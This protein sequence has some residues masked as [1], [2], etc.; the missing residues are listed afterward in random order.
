MLAAP[1]PRPRG[2][3]QFEFSLCFRCII[4]QMPML[5]NQRPECPAEQASATR[6]GEL[7]TDGCIVVGGVLI[8][9]GLCRLIR[10]SVDKKSA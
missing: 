3:A 7:L 9:I 2:F 6:E 8:R 5:D 10:S 4:N 1:V